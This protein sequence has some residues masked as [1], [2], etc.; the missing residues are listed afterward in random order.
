M[1]SRDNDEAKPASTGKELVPVGAGGLARRRQ[2]LSVEL[3]GVTSV[4]EAAGAAQAK[5]LNQAFASVFRIN[6]TMQQAVT[7]VRSGLQAVG[8]AL[9]PLRQSNL[10]LQQAVSPLLQ[11]QQMIRTLSMGFGA[12]GS[13]AAQGQPGPANG[14][15]SPGTA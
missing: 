8:Q 3:S 12:G 1:D 2:Q 14:L 5:E 13:G 9:A 11:N 6:Q 15:V 4:F 7:P 10:L